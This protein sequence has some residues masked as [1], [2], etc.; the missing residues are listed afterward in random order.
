MRFYE[1]VF[2]I[3]P[4]LSESQVEALSQKFAGIIKEQKGEVS[5]TE[6]CGLRTLAYR[7]NK[8]RKGYYVLLNLTCES[9]A[10]TEMERQMR[11][12]EDVMR[13]LTIRVDEL[14]PEPSPL[15]QQQGY[16]D[17]SAS[18]PPRRY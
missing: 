17:S 7:I 12:S 14:N 6:F 5:K 10:I 16:R 13:F 11:L 1:S 8:N 18:R 15:V 9:A 3:R 2:V 4:D